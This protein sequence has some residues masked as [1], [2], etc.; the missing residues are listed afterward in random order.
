MA[1]GRKIKKEEYI[2]NNFEVGRYDNEPIE[3]FL[4]TFQFIIETELEDPLKV[5]P[6]LEKARKSLLTDGKISPAQSDLIAS[7]FEKIKGMAMSARALLIALQVIPENTAWS[8]ELHGRAI[9]LTERYD[10]QSATIEWIEHWA[11]KEPDN[12]A[13]LLSDARTFPDPPFQ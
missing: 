5:A 9:F 3:Y 13:E 12:V 11:Q 4:R 8:E 10:R 1:D 7:I 6:N 2:E